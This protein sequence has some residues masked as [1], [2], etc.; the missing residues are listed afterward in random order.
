[1]NDKKVGRPRNF[2]MDKALLSAINVFWKKG[3]DGT[4]MRDLTSAMG[5]NSPSLYSTFGDKHALYLKAIDRYVTNDACA[6]LI[7]FETEPDIEI[8]VR[9]FMEAALDYATQHESGIRGCFLSS[10]VQ[11]SAGEVDG[12]KE[13]LRKAIDETDVKL[14]ERFELE[15]RKGVLSPEFPSKE[16]ARMMFDLRQGYILRARAGISQEDMKLDLDYR[17][18][19][20]LP[21]SDFNHN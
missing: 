19:V 6:P 16:R 14:A 15:K 2:D 11:T 18:S 13:L 10:C 17:T 1:M 21:K 7:A 3:Y 5:I 8:A 20:I 4:S 9:S 12:A